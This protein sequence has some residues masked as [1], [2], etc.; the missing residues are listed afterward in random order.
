MA[1]EM[2]MTLC[3][4]FSIPLLSSPMRTFRCVRSSLNIQ[5]VCVKNANPANYS[6]FFIVLFSP[7]RSFQYLLSRTVPSRKK[8]NRTYTSWV[9]PIQFPCE[10]QRMR[11]REKAKSR[12][13]NP[14]HFCAFYQAI[15]KFI[16]FSINGFGIVIEESKASL[17][18]YIQ[19]KHK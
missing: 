15:E 5:S 12:V 19:T 11:G 13:K 10:C 7:F 6:P 9:A 16:Y 2:T 1:I 17:K 14:R 3:W 8:K 4:M 18:G